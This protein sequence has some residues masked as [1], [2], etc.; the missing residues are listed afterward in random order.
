[1]NRRPTALHNLGAGQLASFDVDYV[2]EDMWADVHSLIAADLPEPFTVLDIGGGTGRFAD[3]VLASFPRAHATIVDNAPSL[4]A[5]NR[6]DSRK[7]LL[8]E[9]VED[10]PRVLEGRSFDLVCFHWSL[11]HFVTDSYAETVAFQQRSLRQATALVST[12]G[13]VSVFENLYDGLIW[14]SLPGRLVYTMTASQRLAPVT[15]LLGAN[16]AGVGVC[17]LSERQWL[18]AFRLAGLAVE[19]R[20]YYAHSVRWLYRIGLVT[21]RVRKGHFWLSRSIDER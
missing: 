9:S 19:R 8:Q 11:H 1:M 17:F 10:L 7:T 13:R 14:P 3:A 2:T 21:R 6:S 12:R 15:R 16:T 4:L 5:A 18:D 20:H